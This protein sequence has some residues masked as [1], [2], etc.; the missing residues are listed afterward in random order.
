LA[1]DAPR[2]RAVF[3]TNCIIAALKS[4]SPA[5]PNAEL[6]HRWSSGEFD[7]LY[8]EQIRSEY[9][10][11]FAARAVPNEAG[12]NFLALL[13]RFGKQIQI[14]PSQIVAVIFDDPDDDVLLACAV[15]GRATHLVTYDPHFDSLGGSYRGVQIIRPL[16]FLY[17]VRGDVPPSV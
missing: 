15:N 17:L 2:L 3:D 5:S 9:V 10:E 16:Q 6:V 12:K 11:K 1:I 14:I 4:P 8:A 7:L 13:N